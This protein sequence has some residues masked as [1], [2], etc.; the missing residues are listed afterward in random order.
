MQKHFQYFL[1]SSRKDAKAHGLLKIYLFLAIFA[2]LRETI[3]V[4]HDLLLLSCPLKVLQNWSGIYWF[5]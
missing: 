3:F 1:K 5:S 4:R 2:A